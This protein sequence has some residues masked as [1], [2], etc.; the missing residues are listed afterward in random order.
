MDAPTPKGV[1]MKAT[2][3]C[4]AGLVLAATAGTAAA[5][6]P[7]PYP[8]PRPTAPDACAGGFYCSNPYGMTYGPNYYLR[9]AF[10]PFTPLGPG[11]PQQMCKPQIGFPT[12]PYARSPRDF[13]MVNDP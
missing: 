6:Y 12:H 9:P 10:P 1:R 13:F 8:Y 3:T 4:L 2:W 11:L 5:Q 7:A